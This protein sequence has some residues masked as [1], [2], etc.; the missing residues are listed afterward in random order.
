MMLGL[1]LAT[2]RDHFFRLITNLSFSDHP[3]LFGDPVWF[4][5][6]FRKPT[7]LGLQMNNDK[8]MPPNGIRTKHSCVPPTK[9]H[10]HLKSP[11]MIPPL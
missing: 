1:Y 8:A 9:D 10:K 4:V 11:D 7:K 6:D 5:V 3:K 2:G